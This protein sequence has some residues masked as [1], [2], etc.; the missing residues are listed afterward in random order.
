MA[1]LCLPLALLFGIA[2]QY[3]ASESI[4]A[5]GIISMCLRHPPSGLSSGRSGLVTSLGKPGVRSV[6]PSVG[7]LNGLVIEVYLEWNTN[8][9]ADGKNPTSINCAKA[10]VQLPNHLI[11]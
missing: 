1:L 7:R 10:K 6:S 8:L 4:H 11:S 9:E 5:L 2:A 3:D